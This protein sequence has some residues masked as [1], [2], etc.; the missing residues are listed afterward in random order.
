MSA[1]R[2]TEGNEGSSITMSRQGPP[3]IGGH[4]IGVGLDGSSDG[5]RALELALQQSS[6]KDQ[7]HLIHCKQDRDPAY[8][9]I[10]TQAEQKRIEDYSKQIMEIAMEKCGKANRNCIAAP[11]SSSIGT[12]AV[13]GCLVNE[14]IQRGIDTVYVGSH[15]HYNTVQRVLLGS[16]AKHA[17]THAPANVVVVK[18]TPRESNETIPERRLHEETRSVR[19]HVP[20]FVT[21]AQQASTQYLPQPQRL[22]EPTPAQAPPRTPNSP[23]KKTASPDRPLRRQTDTAIHPIS[24][25]DEYQQRPHAY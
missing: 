18:S 25:R 12:S 7:I 24:N 22:T 2:L 11:V 8:Y 14:I 6:E 10:P 21:P 19:E 13:G 23:D 9:H 17:I 20:T 1:E 16:V 5:Y 15:G 3:E 4:L